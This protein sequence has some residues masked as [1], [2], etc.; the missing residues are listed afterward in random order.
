LSGVVVYFFGPYLVLVD[1][2]DV[3]L[4]GFSYM[5]TVWQKG[6]NTLREPSS[7]SKSHCMKPLLSFCIVALLPLT[8]FQKVFSPTR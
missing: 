2:K 4:Y 5:E 7:P 3:F 6:Q 8:Q 1:K